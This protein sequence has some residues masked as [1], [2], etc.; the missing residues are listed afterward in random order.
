MSISMFGLP[1]K[2][3]IAADSAGTEEGK[4]ILKMIADGKVSHEE[5]QQLLVALD[6]KQTKIGKTTTQCKFYALFFPIIAVAILML[7]LGISP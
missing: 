7:I 6:E 2:A 1:K 3:V 4:R 5:G